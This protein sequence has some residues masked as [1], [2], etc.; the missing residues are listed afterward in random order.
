M[1]K[2]KKIVAML[3][4]L[5]MVFGMSVTAFAENGKPEKKDETTVSITGITEGATVT[6][7]QIAKGRYGTGDKELIGY[8]WIEEGLFTVETDETTKVKTV[9]PTANEIIA[10]GYRL[11]GK[12]VNGEA[13]EA[14]TPIDTYGPVT[15]G[16]DGVY[17]QK[18]HAGAYI[19]IISHNDEIY[20]PVLLSASYGSDG[21][22]IAGT[23]GN[24][25]DVADGYLYGTTAVAKKTA[26]KV[27]KEVS[28]GKDDTSA[29]ESVK[30]ASVGDVLTYTV[31]PDMPSYPVNANNKT[32]YIADSMTN[33]LTFIP[34]SIV[35]TVDNEEIKGESEDGVHYTFTA[36][37]GTVLAKAKAESRGEGKLNGF[38]LNFDY[39]KLQNASGAVSQ[40]VI[41]YKAVINEDAVVG[42]AGNKN[43][44]KM[45]YAKNPSEGS[46][47]DPNNTDDTPENATGIEKKEDEK[48]VYTYQISFLKTKEDDTTPLAGAVFGIY[49]K[50]GKLVDQVTTNDK[51]YAV[52]TN[53][54]AGTYTIKE[55]VAPQGYSL[56][57]K[58]YTVEAEWTSATHTVSKTVTDR[59]YTTENPS[60]D[61]VA[62]GW[63]AGGVFYAKEEDIPE[64]MTGKKAYLES[65]NTTTVEEGGTVEN[66]EVG[67][68]TVLLGENIPNTT[69]SSLPSTGGIGTTIFTIAGCLIMILAA[70][71]FFASRRKSA[72]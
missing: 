3:L 21:N 13:A 10:A 65:T 69:L 61:A 37:N 15:V 28:G 38:H 34:S 48:T 17:T 20:N 27:K 6:L 68:G 52:S 33:G 63:I 58:E 41:T 19:A 43:T 40:P 67:A 71:L 31:T 14:L 26:P 39:E 60:E 1:K 4:A 35:I 55:L 42:T 18:V 12:N 22:L 32:F 62:V 44:V 24:P 29:G 2:M 70:G 54:A 8:E 57:E 9:K 25:V 50:D 47:F 64:G 66:S 51:G 7:Y 46:T 49:D 30:T 56:N 5:V 16:S 36:K 72:K 23:D 45:F 59:K 53:V 11:Q